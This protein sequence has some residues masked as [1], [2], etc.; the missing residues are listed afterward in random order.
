MWGFAPTRRSKT[1]LRDRRGKRESNHAFFKESL[2]KKSRGANYTKREL[3]YPPAHPFAAHFSAGTQG[4]RAESSL[5]GHKAHIGNSLIHVQSS[6]P[7][8][9]YDYSVALAY[10]TNQFLRRHPHTGGIV[11]N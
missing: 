11:R 3:S 1:K 7:P 10:R 2:A 9:P 6:P 8:T 4:V 5:R